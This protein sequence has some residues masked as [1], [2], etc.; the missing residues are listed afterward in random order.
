[1]SH[2]HHHHEHDHPHPRQADLEDAPLA[3]YMALTDAVL[4]LLVTKG[5]VTA[6]EV[7]RALELV[8]AA[9]PAAGARMIAKA[10][11][12]PAYKE[13]L[14]ADANAAAGELGI[15]G[16]IIPVRA[17]ESTPTVH[18]LIV[19]TLCSCYPRFILGAAPD[20]YKARAYR[21]RA[22]REPRAVLREFGLDLPDNVRVEVHDSTAELRYMVLPVRPEGTE[23]WDEERL[24]GLVTRDCMIGVAVPEAH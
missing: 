24:A 19:C 22:V 3:H 9:S 21:S 13:R 14:L 2:D 16:G 17:V 11:V 20:W 23:G 18:N 15:D 5:V 10:W 6:G 1:M 8:D 4:D 12:D 7:R